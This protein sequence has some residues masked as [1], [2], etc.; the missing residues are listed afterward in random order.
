[1]KGVC[2]LSKHDAY[3]VTGPTG[4]DT[5]VYHVPERRWESVKGGDI[6]LA[7]GYCQYNPDLDLTA[8]NYQLQCFKFRYVPPDAAASR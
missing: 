6:K 8:M 7:N 5:M 4:S 2:Y 3:L 1:M